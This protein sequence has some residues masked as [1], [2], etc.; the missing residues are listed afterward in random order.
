L[1]Y[2]FCSHRFHKIENYSIF[3]LLKKKFL[4]NFQKTIEL[5]TQKIVTK[6]SKVLFGFRIRDQGSGIRKKPITDPPDP[7]V[8]KAQ[9]PRSRSATLTPTMSLCT[10]SSWAAH[11]PVTCYTRGS[12]VAPLSLW[13]ICRQEAE[14]RRQVELEKLRQ[15]QLEQQRQQ[16]EQR[17]KLEEQRELAR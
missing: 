15:K 12:P 8:K 6:L 9:D 7:G 3:E 11:C 17:R 13:T 10:P 1:S 2:L 4:A 5:F 14:L 16:E